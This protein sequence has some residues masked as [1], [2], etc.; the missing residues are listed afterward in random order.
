VVWGGAR[1]YIRG[2]GPGQTPYLGASER[3]KHGSGNRSADPPGYTPFAPLIWTHMD[4]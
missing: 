1:W 2:M 4:R 3:L